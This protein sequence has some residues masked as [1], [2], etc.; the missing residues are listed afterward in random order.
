[1][2]QQQQFMNQEETNQFKNALK[3]H[4]KNG[5]R[6]IMYIQENLD[7]NHEEL[8]LSIIAIHLSICDIMK[9]ILTRNEEDFQEE[10]S[11]IESNFEELTSELNKPHF[12]YYDHIFEYCRS[13]HKVSV[14]KIN[15]LVIKY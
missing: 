8:V 6:V 10:A 7:G 9:A 12:E 13:Y 11:T 14:L 5:N 4:K 15:K 1:M 2:N 3:E